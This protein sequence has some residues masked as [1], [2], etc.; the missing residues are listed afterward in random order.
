MKP[1]SYLLI[2]VIIF[3]IW[4]FFW[5]DIKVGLL[6]ALFVTGGLYLWNKLDKKYRK[7]E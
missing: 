7:V 1:L 5:R 6:Y 4:G 3:T 2:F